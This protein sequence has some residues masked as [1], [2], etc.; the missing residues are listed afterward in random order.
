MN[1]STAEFIVESREHL[2]VFEQSLLSLERA[3]DGDESRSR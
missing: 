2:A 1:D 3:A